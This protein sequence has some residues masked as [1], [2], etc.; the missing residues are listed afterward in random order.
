MQNLLHL[1]K[2]SLFLKHLIND[3]Q[4]L[5]YTKELQ[6]KKQEAMCI[7]FLICLQAL[8]ENRIDHF[9]KQVNHNDLIQ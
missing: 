9:Q 3:Q 8:E 7:Q 6:L 4:V 1:L 5:D 2:R